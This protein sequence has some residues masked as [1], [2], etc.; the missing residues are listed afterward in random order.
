MKTTYLESNLP[1]KWIYDLIDIL[2]NQVKLICL[3]SILNFIIDNTI[4]KKAISSILMLNKH[5]NGKLK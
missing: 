3:I 1:C 2:L 5:L 4:E